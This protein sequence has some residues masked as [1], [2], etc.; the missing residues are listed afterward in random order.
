M[1][2]IERA[3]ARISAL[4]GSAVLLAMMLQIT[5]DVFMRNFVGAGFPATANI[6]SRYYMVAVSFLPLAM[7]Q[8]ADRHIE[9]GGYGYLREYRAE[10]NWRDARICSI[11]EGANGIHARSLVTRGLALNDSAGA[12]AFSTFLRESSDALAVDAAA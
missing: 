5:V 10:Q 7:T 3:V 8:V 11:Y 4:V 9:A 12:R 2:A 6:V 1:D